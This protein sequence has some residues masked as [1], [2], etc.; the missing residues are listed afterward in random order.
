MCEVNEYHSCINCDAFNVHRCE[1]CDGLGPR[2][3]FN[4]GVCKPNVDHFCRKC[5]SYNLHRSA[6]C[7]G[8]LKMADHLVKKSHT[9]KSSAKVSARSVPSA[10]KVSARS[11]PSAK[12]SA[13]SVFSKNNP[14]E[15]AFKIKSKKEENL[16]VGILLFNDKNEVLIQCGYKGNYCFSGGKF[17]NTDNSLFEGACREFQEESGLDILSQPD[18]FV[19]DKCITHLWKKSNTTVYVF[20]L[21]TKISSWKNTGSTRSE[22]KECNIGTSAC[23]GH[24]WIKP[25]AEIVQS[26]IPLKGI[27]RHLDL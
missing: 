12:V 24:A 5:G 27:L 7:D 25:S 16:A 18:Q 11:V 10:S 15:E 21:K 13:P 3:V 9:V 19:Y 26:T 4:C 22:V 17:E 20:I 2:C 8:K 23:Y 14:F 1:D 6:D